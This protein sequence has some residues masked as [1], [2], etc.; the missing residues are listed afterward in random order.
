[1]K[2]PP[3]SARPHAFYIRPAPGWLEE[4]HEEVLSLL[5]T[6]LHKYKFEPKVTPLK[7][8]VK[9]HRCDWRQGL[10]V[11]LRLT[12]AH[13]M[14]WLI[15]ESRCTKWPDVDAIL[16]RVPWDD[17]LPS[18]EEPVHVT[19]EAFNGFTTVSA[20]LRENLCKIAGVT[21]VSE[22]A[23]LRFKIE[24]RDDFLRVILSLAG[25]PLY[26]RGYKAK[27]A[28]SAPLTEHHAA[29][30]ARYALAGQSATSVFVPFAGSGTLGF[31]AIV[32]LTGG[33]P[34]S[35]PRELACD[36]FPCTPATT[37]SFFRRKLAERLAGAASIRVLFNDFN[38][39]AIAMLR[40]NV[41]AFPPSAKLEIVEGDAFGLEPEFPGDGPILALL[42]PP[43]GERLAGESNIPAL[44]R[45][46][47]AYMAKL[48][49]AYPGRLLGGC[50]C[51][52]PK[53]WRNFLDALGNPAA[54]THHFT[55]GGK[56]MR[57]VRWRA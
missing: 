20:K 23:R 45:K 49:A 30:C 25:D 19:A 40:E 34:G 17:I 1:M 52:D 47:G 32:V 31:E 48:S 12:A 3:I 29:A 37:M 46:L 24:L 33:G 27:L 50:L 39:D 51:P 26:K 16:M 57:I 8:T 54:E 21:H 15:L 43:Y 41:A 36:L 11:L 28:A 9:L 55:H 5:G 35:F 38:A 18:R 2:E 42:N 53:T 22:G 4:V 7:G 44:Y 14:E 56:E 10:E 13:D 6:P